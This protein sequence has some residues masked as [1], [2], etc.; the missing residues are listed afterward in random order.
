MPIDPLSP[1]ALSSAVE[2]NGKTVTSIA[3]LRAP[4][5]SDMLA[6]DVPGDQRATEIALVAR[7]AGVERSTIEDLDW[8]DYEELQARLAGFRSRRE[9]IAAS[10][11]SASPASPAGAAKA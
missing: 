3:L 8:F 2:A 4:K 1:V 6:A 11:S 10:S 5:V 7:L 9:T